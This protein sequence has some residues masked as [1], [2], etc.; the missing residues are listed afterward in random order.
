MNA[1]AKTTVTGA[2]WRNKIV[3]DGAQASLAAGHRILAGL[4]ES[5]QGCA[6]TADRM[7][8]LLSDGLDFIRLR[9]RLS[10]HLSLKA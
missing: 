4:R 10:R 8:A 1:P 3:K 6:R 9:D 5:A 7:S 2:V